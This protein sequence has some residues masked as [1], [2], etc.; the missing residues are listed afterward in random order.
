[1]AQ[2][3]TRFGRLDLNLEPLDHRFGWRLKFRR[4]SGPE[5]ENVQLPG[6]IGSRF[7]FADIQGAQARWEGTTVCVTPGATAWEAVFK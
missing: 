4:G 1:M 3:P 2:S 7:R 5:P 6:A